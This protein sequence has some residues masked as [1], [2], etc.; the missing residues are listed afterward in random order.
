[1]PSLSMNIIQHKSLAEFFNYE[2]SVCI[3][4]YCA[5]IY[6]I[7]GFRVYTSKYIKKNKLK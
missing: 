7:A 5:Y 4:F 3:Q 6:F 2:K 1:M